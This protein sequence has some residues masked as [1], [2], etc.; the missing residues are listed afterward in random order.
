MTTATAAP[1]CKGFATWDP[2]AKTWSCRDACGATGPA[3]RKADGSPDLELFVT[4]HHC[5]GATPIDVYLLDLDEEPMTEAAIRA[6]EPGVVL[7]SLVRLADD[8]ELEEV[9]LRSA[10]EL[11][12][13][14]LTGA[15]VDIYQ[16]AL[17]GIRGDQFAVDGRLAVVHSRVRVVR[18]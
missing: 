18:P 14:F 2:E 3:G 17:D 1:E 10:E 5:A 12:R 15:V 8:V 4:R 9:S 16:N 11:K 13:S 6:F 7:G